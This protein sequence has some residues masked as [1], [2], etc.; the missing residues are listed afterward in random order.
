[1]RLIHRGE[2]PVYWDLLAEA[3]KKAAG[4]KCIRC[5][6]GHSRST[7]HVLTVHHLDGDKSNDRWWNLL[8]LCQRCHLTVQ[9]NVIP[10]RPWMFEHS[11]WFKPYIA[12]F[13]GWQ[14]GVEYSRAEVEPIIEQLLLLG[15][16]WRAEPSGEGRDNG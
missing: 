6:H 3:V 11:D 13:Y 2:Y 16:P 9:A 1:M 8:A 15:Q 10:E 5:G 7:G 4:M 14:H 12:G